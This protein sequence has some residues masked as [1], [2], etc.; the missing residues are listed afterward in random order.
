MQTSN[1]VGITGTAWESQHQNYITT[2][3]QSVSQ[4]GCQ[5]LPVTQ[6][7]IFYYCQLPVCYYGTPS[8]TRGRVCN[9]QLLLVLA[10]AVILGSESCRTNDQILLSH[11][12]LPQP[13]RPGPRIYIPRNRVIQLLYSQTL[14]LSNSLHAN[15]YI[16]SSVYTFNDSFSPYSAQQIIPYQE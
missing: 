15:T 1:N 16:Y 2:D 8:L 6:G 14:G 3:G 4:S 12:R 11:L 10:S 7:Q 5:V 9:L 13:G